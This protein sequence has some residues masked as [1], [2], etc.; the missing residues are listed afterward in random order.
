MLAQRLTFGKCTASI[1]CLALLCFQPFSKAMAHVNPEAMTAREQAL[2]ALKHFNPATALKDFTTNPAETALI[3]VEGDNKSLENHAM[4]ALGRNPA[5]QEVRKS[6][7]SRARVRSSPQSPEMRYAET[8]LT[9]ADSVLEGGCY[10][11][12]GACESRFSDETCEESVTLS[13]K[14]CREMLEVQ[15]KTTTQ[16]SERL[17]LGAT[18]S[19][20]LTFDISACAPGETLCSPSI[21]M[22]VGVPCEA[23][24]VSVSHFGRALSIKKIPTCTDTTV[25]VE[26]SGLARSYPKLSIELTQYSPEDIWHKSD[27][28]EIASA[29]GS[30]RCMLD[31]AGTCLEPDAIR[32]IEGVDVQRACWGFD[33]RYRCASEV[34]GT[35]EPLVS[36]GCSQVASRCMQSVGSW[37]TRYHQ[38]FRC[39]ETFCMPEKTIC[40]GKISCADGACDE[41]TDEP[42]EDLAEGITRL[43]VLAG[44]AAEVSDNQ[45]QSGVAGIFAASA[46]QCKKHPLGARDCC[47]D[48]G[49]GDW[50]MHCPKELQELQRAKVDERVIY[51]GSYKNK[52]LGS[53]HYVYCVFPTTLSAIVQLQGRKDQL[54]I[55]FGDAENPDCRGLTPEELER[56]DFSKLNLSKLEKEW[57]SR[58]QSPDGTLTDLR[59]QRI[60]ERLFQEGRAHD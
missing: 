32:R 50:V 35:C 20:T 17:F 48:S 27:C 47:K 9:D 26:L 24:R 37:C 31:T 21:L 25:T 2:N 16:S 18:G 59:N 43:G 41:T 28:T 53:R 19:K 33:K 23:L 4:R 54:H 45:I 36:Q 30:A 42:T 14:S 3:P 15:L 10:R 40:P 39:R 57:M 58:M 52:K 55:P 8:L 6:A 7:Q 12:A 49:W 29:S 60:I 38:T 46:T 56:I 22:A 34:S 5:A 51:L 13:E 11:E 44:S 1:L